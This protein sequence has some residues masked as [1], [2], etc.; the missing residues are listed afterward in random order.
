MKPLHESFKEFVKEGYSM[1]PIYQE[2]EFVDEIPLD[3]SAKNKILNELTSLLKELYTKALESGCDGKK[4]KESLY[5][6]YKGTKIKMNVT[7]DGRFIFDTFGKFPDIVINLEKMKK[8]NHNKESIQKEIDNQI[9]VFERI[10]GMPS[11]SQISSF[12]D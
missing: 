4:L 7:E 9:K 12:Q 6:K 8:G 2:E 3:K 10:P 5:P 1:Q 11:K